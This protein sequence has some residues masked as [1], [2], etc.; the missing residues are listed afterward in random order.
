M[1]VVVG[2]VVIVAV[3]VVVAVVVAA[4]VVVE[5]VVKHSCHHVRVEVAE[6]VAAGAKRPHGRRG[7]VV[8]VVVR[9]GGQPTRTFELYLVNLQRGCTAGR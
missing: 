5:V 2:D 9:V 8:A 1:V 7:V 6:D 4:V 3:V